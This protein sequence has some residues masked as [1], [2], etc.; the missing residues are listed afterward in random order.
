[1]SKLPSKILVVDSDVQVIKGIE[2][3]LESYQV[4]VEAAP[5]LDTALYLFN[6]K[7]Y[8]VVLIDVDFES[9][10]GLAFVQKWR[11]HESLEKQ[12]C[13]FVMMT[14]NQKLDDRNSGL[15][16]EL[17]DLEVISKPFNVAKI[18]PYL[19]RGLAT[20]Q[21]LLAYREFKQRIN[22]VYK[23][24]KSYDKVIEQIKQKLPELGSEGLAMLFETYE[25][26]ERLDEALSI[27]TPMAEREPHNISL[28]NAKGRILMRLGKF[29]EAK[30]YLEKAD[31]LAPQNIERIHEMTDMYLKLNQPDHA[32][33]K[34][35][36]LVGLNPENEELKFQMYSKLFNEGFDEHAVKFGKDT[37]NPMEIVRH[38]NNKGVMLSKQD[39]RDG[40]IT[41]YNRA[42]QFF[43]KFKENYRIYYNIALALTNTKTRD[44]YTKAR[45]ALL[46]C[47]KL[48]PNFEK[49]KNTLEVVERALNK[50][51]KAS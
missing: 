49:A 19:S 26:A 32:V 6:Q 8:E 3:M 15:I 25:K 28:Q 18:L 10:P 23:R 37:A 51:K 30:K 7:R 31:K 21:R 43:P 50:N 44:S 12:A 14:G 38:Y 20:R 1:M 36:E 33:S 39:D 46:K 2:R 17:G 40:A 22:G 29:D 42:L 13:G 48:S 4:G 47:L 45:E 9:L 41:E 27:I 35:Q 24:T 16:K 11:K 34:M 5:Q